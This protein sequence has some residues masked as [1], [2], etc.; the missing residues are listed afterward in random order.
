MT[1]LE[2]LQEIFKFFGKNDEDL[3]RTYD[4]ALTTRDNI[5]WGKLY[6]KII[7][8]AE[9]RYLPAP[10]WFIGM[11]PSCIK[12]EQGQYRYDNGTGV[13]RLKDEKLKAR[14]GYNRFYVFDMW[15]TTHTIDEIYNH[16]K[17]KYG[18]KFIDFKY[19]P[20]EFSIIGRKIFDHNMQQ[21]GVIE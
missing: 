16:F 2:F 20:E 17:A 8:E 9:S 6:K 15:H 5:D 3:L 19:Y 13:L 11:F 4:M 18:S 10:K 7:T 21:C 14:T 12:Y 1:R